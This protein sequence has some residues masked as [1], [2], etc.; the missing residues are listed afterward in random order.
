[1]E[2]DYKLSELSD[3]GEMVQD[4]GLKVLSSLHLFP[5]QYVLQVYIRSTV[6]Q[7]STTP[8]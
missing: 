2:S 3:S 8:V 6:S 4:D 7:L 5:V 1:M